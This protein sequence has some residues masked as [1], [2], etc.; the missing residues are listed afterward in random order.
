MA[1]RM[2][3][4]QASRAGGPEV[5]EVAERDVPEPGEGELLVE[6]AA[7]GV[8]F[9][10]VYRR[11][12]TY[13]VAFPHVPGTEGA[14]RVAAVGP[15]VA[16]FAVGDRVATAEGRETYARFAIVP[17]AAAAHV[18]DG[19]DDET[20]AALPLQGLTAHYL[21]TSVH[22][23]EAGT[24]LLVHAGAG[25]VGLLLIQL[26]KARGA[27]VFTTVGSD[28]KRDLAQAAGADAVVEYDGFAD[29]VRSLNGGNGVDVVYDGVGATTVDGSLASLRPRGLLA[30]FGAASGP[31]PPI[32]PTRL[33][34]GG[35]LV[36]TRP[37][38]GDFLQTPEERAWR[39]RELFGAVTEGRLDVRVGATFVLPDAGEAHR[40][41][42]GRRTTG[43]VLLEG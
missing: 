5:L 32:D 43:K 14:G 12:G 2:Q 9:V 34:R 13:P 4:V 1:E 17:A 8:N 6:L 24:T 31:V 27:I 20:A 7:T 18:P 15:G 25:G 28:A 33:M 21:L 38:M 22:P 37:T 30:L 23:V 39:Y 42:E 40:A 10:D 16:G 29:R 35:S 41:L 11:T 3:V 26:A 36:L 19:V